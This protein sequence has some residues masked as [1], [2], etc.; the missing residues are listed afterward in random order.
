MNEIL[1]IC[2]CLLKVELLSNHFSNH[3]SY[4]IVSHCVGHLLLLINIFEKC[5]STCSLMILISKLHFHAKSIRYFRNG[6]YKLVTFLMIIQWTQSNWH[7]E[8]FRVIN[9]QLS[10]FWKKII[11]NF[12]IFSYLWHFLADYY[13]LSR[14]LRIYERE[15]EEIDG[16]TYNWTGYLHYNQNI[17]YASG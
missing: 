5:D 3:C 14:K 4:I 13:I 16:G 10:T 11:Q 8:S 9:L 12:D 1:F 2:I 7:K 17:L 15:N 6:R